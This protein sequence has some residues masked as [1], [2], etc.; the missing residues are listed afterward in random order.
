MC[1]PG[2]NG[3]VLVLWLVQ[4]R[5]DVPCVLR[6]HE[7]L[8]L[9]PGVMPDR[10]PRPPPGWDP[11]PAPLLSS[12]SVFRPRAHPAHDGLVSPFHGVSFEARASPATL[13]DLPE[14][15]HLS[16]AL[17]STC[18]TDVLMICTVLAATLS[19]T[20]LKPDCLL[21]GSPGRPDVAQGECPLPVP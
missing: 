16:P 7:P 1:E 5:P 14:A 9:G 13:A 18:D 17:V 2:P 15:G 19:P 12:A 21:L 8:G 6:E 4:P 20:C 10:S 3:P 11:G